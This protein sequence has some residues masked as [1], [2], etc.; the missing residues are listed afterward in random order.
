[1]RPTVFHGHCGYFKQ[2][3]SDYPLGDGGFDWWGMG[4]GLIDLLNQIDQ[5]PGKVRFMTLD[6]R[7]YVHAKRDKLGFSVAGPIFSLVYEVAMFLNYR[8]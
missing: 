6:A 3:L 1:M 4:F 5:K 8:Y 2:N 7:P